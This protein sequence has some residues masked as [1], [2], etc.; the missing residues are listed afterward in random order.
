MNVT[1]VGAGGHVG[2]PLSLVLADSGHFVYGLDINKDVNDAVMRGSMPFIE[3]NA[4]ELL[5][6]VLNEKRL[7]MTDNIEVIGKSDVVIVIIGTPIDENLNPR[8]DHLV[9]FFRRAQPYLRDQL[10][11]LRS[12]VSPGTTDVV[13]KVIEAD[14][15]SGLDLVFG[16]ERVLQ[17]K[18][19]HEIRNLPQIIGAYNP[20]AYERAAAFFRTFIRSETIFLTPIEAEL[21]KLI[22]N[23]AR[24]VE[25]A[26]ANEFHLICGTFGA[27]ACRVIDACNK[28]YPRLNLPVPGPNVG[29][30]CLYK[31]GWYLIE[32]VPFN[33]MISSAFRINEGMTMQILQNI[34]K[35]IPSGK[36]AILG[37][38]FKANS[39]DTRNSLSFKMRR[40]LEFKGYETV[41]V[42][43]YVPGTASIEE[44]RGCDAVVLMSPHKQFKDLNALLANVD[45]R[46]CWLVDLWGFWPEMRHR[47]DNGYFQ[48]RQVRDSR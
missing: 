48:A 11:I 26:L 16:P 2:L 9:R 27:N 34:E 22:T 39:D 23:M 40:Q 47:S 3:E 20:H 29:G 15:G 6:K 37:M 28:D 42:D 21:G 17:G 19:I 4:E 43:P 18:A 1:V 7:Q 25:F 13:R 24:Y 35:R 33:E 38:A 30:P 14:R 5:R 31:D 46:D 8:V 45:N 41:C 44:I 12:T 32:R 36:V 10:V